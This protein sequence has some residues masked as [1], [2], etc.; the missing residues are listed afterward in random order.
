MAYDFAYQFSPIVYIHFPSTF[1]MNENY[2]RNTNIVLIIV[3]QYHMPMTEGFDVM[4]H[5]EVIWC[6]V[7]NRDLVPSSFFVISGYFH[8]NVIG[9]NKDLNQIDLSC[10]RIFCI[11]LF[12]ALVCSVL[13]ISDS[14]YTNIH[15]TFSVL[16]T[17]KSSFKKKIKWVYN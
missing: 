14:S 8:S 5:W 7:K 15:T 13:Y 9:Y 11:I 17:S 6:L 3:M 10:G 12:K 2:V 1:Q 4:L 16:T